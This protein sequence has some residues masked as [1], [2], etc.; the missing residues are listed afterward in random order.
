M[1]ILK[2]NNDKNSIF[3]YELSDNVRTKFFF[4]IFWLLSLTFDNENVFD[5]IYKWAN[6]IRLNRADLVSDQESLCD[7]Q[8]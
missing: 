5:V 6:L 3:T 4:V 7:V 8:R 2:I 1:D